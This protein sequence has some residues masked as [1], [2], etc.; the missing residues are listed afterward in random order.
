MTRGVKFL[1]IAAIVAGAGFALKGRLMPHGGPPGGMDVHG[2]P[3]PVDVAEVI[4][5][6][7]RIWD[8]FSGRLVAAEQAWVR[9]RVA[10]MIESVH[11]TDGAAV[12]KGDL[13]FTI[14]RRPYQAA[15]DRAQGAVASA[16]AQNDLAAAELERAERL[17]KSKAVSAQDYDRRKND[18]AVAA[19]G[20]ASAQ[21]ALASAQI[22]LDYTQIRAPVSGR[23]GRVEIT[24]GNL[25]EAGPGAPVLTGVVAQ[26]PVYADFEMDEG[27]FRR[28]AG[29]GAETV[30]AVLEPPPGG[31]A[32]REGRVLAFDN[33]LD[34]SSGTIRVRAVFDNADGAL[35]PGM[36]A[37]VRIGQPRSVPAILIS[38]RAVGTDQNKKF[39]IVAGK[40]DTAEYREIVP[41]PTA[42]GLRVVESGLAPGDRIVVGGLQR[43]RPGTKIEPQAVPMEEGGKLPEKQESGAAAQP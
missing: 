5:R 41:G 4:S 12:E 15:V 32:P 2:G 30:P 27:T 19:A 10:G 22:D 37:R 26:S 18:A 21:A 42:E 20:L 34:P 7:V 6:D 14:D 8:E 1:L 23:A 11:F 31:G 36:F 38:D 17:L 28:F 29:A 25:V 13:L 40:D 9:P 16:Q 43:A 3:A 35:V 39:V 33:R 24:A